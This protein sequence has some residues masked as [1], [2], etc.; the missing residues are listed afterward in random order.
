MN[1]RYRKPYR[2][3][4][5]SGEE[6]PRPLLWNKD[7]VEKLATKT[8]IHTGT[9]TS[10]H[11]TASSTARNSALWQASSTRTT[12]KTTKNTSASPPTTNGTTT[13]AI[14]FDSQKLK[15]TKDIFTVGTWN[16]PTL[17]AAG[18]LELLRNEMKRYRYDVIS[19]S[20]VRWTGKGETSNGYFFWSEENNTHTKGVGM[21][22][23]TKAK[24][25]FLSYNPINSRLITARFNATS[26]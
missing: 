24:K 14:K 7:R 11:T 13:T 19:I 10:K 4:R 25:S 23:S 20:E 3:G 22:L 26:F 1:D 17:W 2:L 8:T 21:L 15:M 5:R 12:N 6:G 9:A 18:K 16:V